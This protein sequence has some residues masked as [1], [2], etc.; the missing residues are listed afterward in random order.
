MKAKDTASYNTC[1]ITKV[2][3][4]S[5]IDRPFNIRPICFWAF[6]VALTITICIGAK[7]HPL[8]VGFYFIALIAVFIGLQFLKCR[9]KVINFFGHSRINFIVTIALCLVVAF[10]F[11]ITTLLHTHQ[12]SFAGFCDLSGVVENYRIEDDGSGWFVLHDAKFGSTSIGGKIWVY[13]NN[14]NESALESITSTHRVKFNT[15]LRNAKAN[16]FYINNGI[17]Y[18][19]NVGAHDEV[20]MLGASK[21]PRSVILR[22]CQS[23]LRK[24]MSNAG[25]DLMYAMLFGDRS[26]LDGDLS[27]RFSLSGLAHVL[28]VSGLHVGII[29]RLLVI[30]LKLCRVSRKRQIPIIVSVLLLYCYLCGFRFSILWAAIMFTVFV[31]QRAFLKSNDLL[32][33]MSLA[34]ILILLLF[35]YAILSVSF[36]FTFACMLGI[37]LFV[38]PFSNFFKKYVRCN[39]LS[40]A[41]AMYLA[42]FIT[43]LPLMIKYFGFVSLVGIFTNVLFLPLLIVS[44][45]ICILAVLTW[46]AFPLLYFVNAVLDVMISLTHWVSRLPFSHVHVSGGGYAFLL[47]LLGLMFTTRFIFLRPRYKYSAATFLILIYGISMVL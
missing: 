2:G 32:S 8:W 36:Q 10:S 37:A 3:N 23:F 19:A 12:K 31:I 22:Y 26:T 42:T 34:A 7:G 38:L 17:K 43:V 40:N 15:Q 30:L 13:I 9:D 24:H 35:P 20:V 46:I 25:A 41:L 39:W 44:F 1:A 33:S 29:V 4:S 21:S 11:A 14:P 18:T 47:Y 5:Y 6:F 16:D 28:A 27:E 45:Q